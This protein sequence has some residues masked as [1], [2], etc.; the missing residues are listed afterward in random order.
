MSKSTTEISYLSNKPGSTRAVGDA[1][2]KNK[3]LFRC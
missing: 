1:V 3:S 2:V